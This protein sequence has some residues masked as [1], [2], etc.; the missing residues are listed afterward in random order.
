MDS[1]AHIILGL[2]FDATVLDA[3][4]GGVGRSIPDQAS[5]SQN[6]PAQNSIRQ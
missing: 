6:G 5:M 3:S 2:V 4:V 1:K